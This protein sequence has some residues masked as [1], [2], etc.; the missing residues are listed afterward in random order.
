ME[1]GVY[2]V[3]V[4]PQGAADK[5]GLKQG[6]R[7]ISFDGKEVS[8]SAEV[9]AILREHKIGDK[10]NMTVSRDGKTVDVTITLQQQSS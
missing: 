8:T 1:D 10:V 3:Q 7:I 4:V 9:K 6:D 2:I 5:A